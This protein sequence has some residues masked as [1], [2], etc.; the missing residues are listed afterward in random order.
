MAASKLQYT[1][2]QKAAKAAFKLQGILLSQSTNCTKLGIKLFDSLVR[3]VLTY[4]CQVWGANVTIGISKGTT[5]TDDKQVTE[6]L[7]NTYYKSLVG[8]KVS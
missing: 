5:I 1:Q 6:K 7:C 4:G 2:K 8:L 3:P